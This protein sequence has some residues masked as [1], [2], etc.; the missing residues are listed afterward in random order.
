M[1]KYLII[2]V[3]LTGCYT[4]PVAVRQHAKAATTYPDIAADYC[5]RVYPS[6]DSLIKG[7]T[8]TVTDT[9][10]EGGTSYIDTVKVLDTVRITK[11]ITLPAKI[12]TRTVNIHDTVIKVNT[13]DLDLCNIERRKVIDSLNKEQARA[14]KYQKRAKVRGFIL[15]GLLLAAIVYLYFKLKGK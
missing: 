7:D 8:V 4:R 3:L 11:T 15:L 6:K 12:I 1:I 13:A 10:Y 14:D 9:I 2:L 5:A